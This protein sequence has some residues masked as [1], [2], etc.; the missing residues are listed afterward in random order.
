MEPVTVAEP[1]EKSGEEVLDSFCLLSL[2]DFLVRDSWIAWEQELR[3]ARHEWDKSLAFLAM[4][5]PHQF[6]MAEMLTEE[7]QARYGIW[8]APYLN[9]PARSESEMRAVGATA[10][11]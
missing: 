9:H 2:E 6:V 8:K 4:R 3:W 1:T 11:S 5:L 7:E 10:P